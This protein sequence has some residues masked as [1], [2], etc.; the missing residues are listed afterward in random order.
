MTRDATEILEPF[1][2][3]LEVLAEL[4]LDRKLRGKLDPSDVVQQTMLR[5][6]SALAEVRDDRPEV[7]VAWLRR[8]L[9]R[10]LADAAKHFERDKEKRAR[11]CGAPPS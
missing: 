10:T 1:R 9:A 8:I 3:H 7:V 5:A 2:K 11:T 6:Y 4:H